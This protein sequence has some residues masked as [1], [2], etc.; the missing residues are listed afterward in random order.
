ML[1][2][3]GVQCGVCAVWCH[4]CGVMGLGLW[5]VGQCGSCAACA[6]VY[7]AHVW[8][9]CL[10]TSFCCC[11]TF[12]LSGSLSSVLPVHSLIALMATPYSR[13][14]KSVFVTFVCCCIFCDCAPCL[15][16][17]CCMFGPVSTVRRLHL[18]ASVYSQKASPSNTHCTRTAEK[19]CPR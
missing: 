14:R 13:L 12:S 17:A 18:N 6:T 3:C 11:C 19:E 10:S 4:W 9:V 8:L 15:L 1:W 7:S 16:L 2:A 5:V